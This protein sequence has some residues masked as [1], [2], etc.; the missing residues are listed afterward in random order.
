M[1]ADAVRGVGA[2][3]NATGRVGV[4]LAAATGYG[5]DALGLLAMFSHM[6]SSSSMPMAAIPILAWLARWREGARRGKLHCAKEENRPE[7][8]DT[9]DASPRKVTRTGKFFPK[10][11]D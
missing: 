8:L 1:V 6:S 10:S 4:A 2:A 9:R 3:S 7:N 11:M 5:R